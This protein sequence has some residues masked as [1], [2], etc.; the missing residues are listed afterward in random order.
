M[1]VNQLSTQAN[2]VTC[3]RAA[4]P[5]RL[6]QRSTSASDAALGSAVAATSVEAALRECARRYRAAAA[7]GCTVARSAVVAF[8]LAVH[9]TVRRG[10][11][12]SAEEGPP[13]Q[14]W[15]LRK[16]RCHRSSW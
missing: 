16:N 4:A 9:S 1:S 5:V 2:L 6:L 8:M 11:S 7:A 15:S 3:T 10:K 12:A 13:N 14:F